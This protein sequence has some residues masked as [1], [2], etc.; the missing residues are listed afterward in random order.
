MSPFRKIRQFPDIFTYL[1]FRALISMIVASQ[2]SNH[3]YVIMLR[4]LPKSC[5]L[6]NVNFLERN[7][8]VSVDLT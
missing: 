1:K 6:G 7:I 4:P 5:D 3:G 8:K 2:F